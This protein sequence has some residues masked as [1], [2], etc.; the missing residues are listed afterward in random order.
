MR[1][2]FRI[3]KIIVVVGVSS[4]PHEVNSMLRALWTSLIKTTMLNTKRSE[5]VLFFPQQQLICPRDQKMKNLIPLY[6][7]LSRL[8]EP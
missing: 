3:H 6:L 2:V 1:G 4:S 8:E 7:S 5:L